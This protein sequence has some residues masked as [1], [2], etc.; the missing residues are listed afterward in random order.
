MSDRKNTANYYNQDEFDRI[1]KKME[2]NPWKAKEQFE[3]YLKIYTSDY[4]AFTYYA[5]FLMTLGFLKEA[6]VVIE[7][8]EEA[9]KRDSKYLTNIDREKLNILIYNILYAKIKL[10]CRL[11]R[12]SEAIE[13]YN[14]NI[15]YTKDMDIGQI[16]EFCRIKLNLVKDAKRSDYHYLLRQAFK[17]RY[18]DFLCHVSKHLDDEAICSEEK[19]NIFNNNFPIEEVVKEIKQYLGSDKRLRNGFIDDL[20]FFKYDNCGNIKGQPVNYFKVITFIDSTDIITMYPIADGEKLPHVDLNYMIL[21]N[22]PLVR[23]RSQI[24]KFNAKWNK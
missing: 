6:E 3:N 16:I 22:A 17:Y 13:L 5:S 10:L 18:G 21:N 11:K 1:L 20:Y 7:N 2:S 15:N 14:S 12:Y 8:L 9:Y 19:T 4:S 23:R 24:D